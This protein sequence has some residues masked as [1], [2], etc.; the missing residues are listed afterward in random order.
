V[1]DYREYTIEDMKE[2]TD[3]KLRW[4]R[5]KAVSNQ[6]PNV[7][8]YYRYNADYGLLQIGIVYSNADNLDFQRRCFIT[9]LV[10][11]WTGKENNI[12]I[13]GNGEQ[14]FDLGECIE[15]EGWEIPTIES[16]VIDAIYDR[17]GNLLESPIYD[18]NVTG[19][20]NVQLRIT[21]SDDAIACKVWN[22]ED[23][24]S[25]WS[26]E[27]VNEYNKETSDWEGNTLR[28]ANWTL[29]GSDDGV[30]KIKATCKNIGGIWSPRAEKSIKLD[31][32]P[33]TV[34]SIVYPGATNE[35]TV[36]ISF[37]AT[38][39]FGVESCTAYR[40]CPTDLNEYTC[41]QTNNYTM[42]DGTIRYE[43]KCSG[44][45]L[46]PN[47]QVY[48]DYDCDIDG[49]NMIE[50]NC[51]DVN[52]NTGTSDEIAV[53]RLE[54]GQPMIEWNYILGEFKGIRTGDILGDGSVCAP[55]NPEETHHVVEE[56][57]GMMCTDTS[58]PFYVNSPDVVIPIY[59]TSPNKISGCTIQAVNTQNTDANGKVSTE[60]LD[61]MPIEGNPYAQEYECH[62]MVSANEFLVA[63][64]L[65]YLQ[66]SCSAIDEN[67]NI[68]T[69]PRIIYI[70]VDTTPPVLEL[71]FQQEGKSMDYSQ[72]YGD[73]GCYAWDH[74]D[75]SGRYI[76]YKGGLNKIEQDYVEDSDNTFSIQTIWGIDVYAGILDNLGTSHTFLPPMQFDDKEECSETMIVGV[77]VDG[78]RWVSGGSAV[79]VNGERK[80]IH[81]LDEQPIFSGN[82]K[83]WKRIIEITADDDQEHTY[84]I[85]AE[86]KVGNTAT[87]TLTIDKKKMYVCGAPKYNQNKWRDCS[88]SKETT[89]ICVSSILKDCCPLNDQQH[90]G[91]EGF[92]S[93]GDDCRWYTITK[94]W[95][96]ENGGSSTESGCYSRHN[97]TV[98]NE[99][100][101]N[102]WRSIE[103]GEAL[104]VKYMKVCLRK[105]GEELLEE[106]DKFYIKITPSTDELYT[107]WDSVSNWKSQE[108]K[109]KEKSGN[110]NIKKILCQESS[111]TQGEWVGPKAD[112]LDKME[113]E[114]TLE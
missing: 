36:T 54:E 105:G 20:R 77:K 65:N 50:V 64:G 41:T 55:F 83:G 13:K 33:P 16:F 106:E 72:G 15:A 56:T 52:G 80:K 75:D 45:N 85:T 71:A 1:I 90:C 31:A 98:V 30:Y 48:N 88:A 113:V 107:I 57:G 29:G 7:A 68:Q 96:G 97:I 94:A 101:C 81:D 46:M 111:T 21:T 104:T 109:C 58:G 14:V 53:V 38:D 84:T 28:I 12:E 27:R 49:A 76:A 17:D 2:E 110:W 82:D 74:A 23:E 47:K 19:N 95:G 22:A 93:S 18:A 114:M 78:P 89:D 108:T 67:G 92:M 86:D 10:A 87:M 79:I 34:L 4:V 59:V 3:Q 99:G 43:F 42:P 11:F 5:D 35:T 70:V 62:T 8:G 66:I 100:T 61:C 24:G 69:T 73:A 39:R 63:E 32:T 112:Y 60:P 44:I 6:L 103:F 51:T 26:F 40:V 37:N 102:Q 25:Y 91:I 9:N